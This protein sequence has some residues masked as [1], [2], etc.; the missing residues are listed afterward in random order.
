[1]SGGDDAIGRLV[2][3]TGAG[4]RV[5]LHSPQLERLSI[6]HGFTTR[7]GGLNVRGEDDLAGSLADAGLLGTRVRFARQFHAARVSLHDGDPDPADAVFS[8]PGGPAAAVRTAD[9][10][11]VLF[12]G[13][14]GVVAAHAGWR[15]LLAGVLPAAVRALGG[16]T[17]VDAVALG[18]CIG[19]DAFEVGP[20]V[21]DAFRSAG[22]TAFLT[23]GRDDRSH[24]DLLG[25]AL[26][27]LR[28]MEVPPGRVDAA[29]RCTWSE[30]DSFYSFRRD[31]PG[32]GHLAAWVRST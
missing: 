8:P 20:E 17:A 2:E 29:G 22:F 27:Q 32:R 28:A 16:G 9:C 12:A 3:R 25:A 13:P 5:S 4:G 6:A 10:L 24:V 21:A 19:P 15:G 26:E 14:A 23:A 31:G 30:P 1:M 18:P 7:A 11:G